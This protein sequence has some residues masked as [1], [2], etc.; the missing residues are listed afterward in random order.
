MKRPSAKARLQSDLRQLFR[1][2]DFVSRHPALKRDTKEARQ[3]A[4]VYQQLGQAWEF[5]ALQCNHHAGWRK[6]RQGKRVCKI[7]GTVQGAPE[8]WLLLPREGTKTIGRRSIPN[9]KRIFK[10]RKAATIV[11]DTVDFHGARLN[12]EMLNRHRSRFFRDRDWTIAA[13][14]LV[15]LKE[16]G[17][18]CRFDDHLISIKLKKHKRGEQPPYGAF[19][20]ELP[21]KLLKNFPVLLEYDKRRRFV[22]LTIFRPVPIN[23]KG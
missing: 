3:L 9:S 11:N 23:K 16:G 21:R 10:N 13:D 5:L 19:V 18:E 8:P 7:C 2:M 17:I 15:S 6:T 4:A 1:S 14:R 22:G 12:V 20:W